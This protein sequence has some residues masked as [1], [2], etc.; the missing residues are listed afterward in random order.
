[1]PSRPKNN[2][3]EGSQD[4]GLI[5]ALT[6]KGF[7]SISTEQRID[8]CPLTIL[9]GANSSGK[10]SMMQ[11]ALLIKQTLES[12][13]DPGPLL[14]NGPNVRMTAFDQLFSGSGRVRKA[15]SSR[16]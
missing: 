6:V 5:T 7:K 9:A 10:S 3:S 8:I 16:F 15:L 12:Q 4:R 14:I 1:M 13:Y 11:P 2:G